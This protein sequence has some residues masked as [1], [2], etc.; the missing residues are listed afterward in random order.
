[1]K[2]KHTL[3]I[4][5]ILII[6][7]QVPNFTIAAPVLQLDRPAYT[8]FDKMIITLT[9]SSLNTD[10]ETVETVPVTISGTAASEQLVL[11]ETGPNTG[12]FQKDVTLTADPN[13]Y[14]GDLQVRR[15]DGITISYRVDSD[16]VLT[17]TAFI[18][19]NEA[20]A[21]FDKPS[22]QITDSAMISVT[23]L[24]ASINPDLPD[25][26]TVKVWSDTDPNGFTL[27]L[28]ETDRNNGI[29]EESLVFTLTGISS[30]NRLKVSDGDTV[31]M[32]Y[33]DNTLPEPAKLSADGINTLES[34]NVVAT[35]IFG[36]F[37]PST[38][39]APV[40]EP[41]L[42]N[43]FGE[44]VSQ[45]FTGEQL[46][47]QSEVTNAQNKKQP[48]AYIVQVKN[49][50]GI[51]VS[52]S[53]VTS[54]LPPNESLKVAQSWLPSTSGSYSIE[55]FVWESLTNPTALSPTR[56]KSIEVLK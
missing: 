8:A 14:L 13:K 2:L 41:T 3:S 52:L 51:T 12:K 37:V 36:K 49:S 44:S 26:V 47:I 17:E 38:Q 20:E 46:L 43:S 40:A 9:D 42:V 48:F 28:R 23:D 19:Y 10:N 29:F 6:L 27:A 25:T 56:M 39:R 34:K 16:N 5:S 53:W 55:I 21:S 30:G 45:I 11:R 7:L 1:M 24:D 22:Y 4:F 50:D 35:T 15:D 32:S 18:Q 31:S 33:V 54:E